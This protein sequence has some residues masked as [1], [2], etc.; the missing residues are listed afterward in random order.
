M[1]D[2]I[3]KMNYKELRDEVQLLR[4]EL[5]KFKRQFT[6]AI[7]NIDTDNFSSRFVKEQGEMR[8]AVKIAADGI[9]TKV[10][11]ED[12]E[13]TMKQ[14][15]ESISGIVS[16]FVDGSKVEMVGSP[17]D[18]TDKSKVYAIYENDKE[19]HY[20]YNGISKKWEVLKDNGIIN[21][22]FEQTSDGFK[23]KGSVRVDGSCILT[24]SLV[25]DASDR[26]L[27]VEYSADGTSYWH[28]SFNAGSDKFMR[29]KI[30]A[31]WSDAMKIVGD[32]GHN[33]VDAYADAQTIFNILTAGG[34]QQGL[35]TAFYEDEDKL[36]INAEC[37]NTENLACTRLYAKN[38]FDGYSVR[39]NGNI[40]DFGIFNGNAGQYASALDGTCMFG[41]YNQ[42]PNINFYSYGDLFLIKD[43]NVG[44][45]RAQGVWDFSE[46]DGLIMPD[47]YGGGSDGNGTPYAVF[48]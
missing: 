39:L 14:T 38:H 27:E 15:A 22:L 3:T 35:F 42:F 9:E 21:S 36:F 6:D 10:S 26:P 23:L 44:T 48:G 46:V 11:K 5:A 30:G 1:S 25:F 7:N 8:T 29:L 43:N 40:G 32:N 28:S 16:E 31:Q 13:S 17:A 47:G 18:F 24:D 20:Y 19:V 12:F 33:G 2:D 37:I 4:D 41:V 34:T 45:T